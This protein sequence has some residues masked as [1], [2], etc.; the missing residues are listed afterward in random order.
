MEN[1]EIKFRG[2]SINTKQMIYSMTIAK[3]TIKR[4]LGNIYFEVEPNIWIGVDPK[5]VSQ[6]TGLKDRNSNEIYGGDILECDT[7]KGRN[8]MTVQYASYTCYEGYR[9]YGLNKRFNVPLTRSR[10]H[11]FKGEVI[12]N[13]YQN[14]EL[15]Q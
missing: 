5:T 13:I 14:P 15:L 3:G 2:L 7:V 1:R 10:V 6:F 12:G 4:K 9:I 11:N 8:K